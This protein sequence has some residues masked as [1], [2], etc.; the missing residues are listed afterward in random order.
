M[1]R[2]PTPRRLALFCLG[3]LLSTLPLSAATRTWTGTSSNLWSVAA[4]W[5]GTA[6]VA[7]D[8]LVFPAGAA[9]QSTMN[10]FAAGTS[11]NSI[12]ITG[13]SYT[14][15]GNAITLGAG[16]LSVSVPLQQISL[17]IT[18]GTSQMWQTT[19]I[20]ADFT[21]SGT[22]NLN[23]ATLTLAISSTFNPTILSGVISGAGAIVKTTGGELRVDGANTYTG[24]TTVNAGYFLAGNATAAGVADGTPA[25]G[26]I[27]NVNSSFSVTNGVTLGNEWISA[28]GFGQSGNGALQN[29]SC[30]NATY[31]GP[32]VLS[33]AVKISA[34]GPGGSIVFNGPISGSPTSIDIFGTSP[35]SFNNAANSFSGQL[36]IDTFGT[37][38]TV[39]VGATNAIPAAVTV[40]VGA[41]ETLALNNFNDTIA[42]LT[43]AGNVSL[44]SG[45]LTISGTSTGTFSGVISGTGSVTLGGAQSLTLSGPNTAM[46]TLTDNGSTLV[47]AGATAAWP[48]PVVLNNGS[49]A[50]LAS[51]A[52]IGPLTV[53]SGA[54]V[55][56]GGGGSATANTG[57]LTFAS[58]GVYHALITGTAAGAFSRLNVTGTVTLGGAT[59]S[60][61]PSGGPYAAGTQFTIIDNDGV[62][63]VTGTFA[64]LAQGATIS[65]G[66]QSYSIS[67]TAGTGNDVV[68]T[69]LAATTPTTTSLMSSTNPS[70]VGQPV[71]FTATVSPVNAPPPTGTVTFFDG[72]T[73]IGSSPVNVSGV[74]T[75][76]T[77]ALAAGPH[78]ITATYS[79]D[80]NYAGSTS[81]P[82]AQ[83]V[84]AA[85][86]PALDGR[87]L[88]ALLLALAVAGAV[89][90]KR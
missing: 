12:A 41:N 52:T 84:N 79:G 66:G 8:D 49:A 33:G 82:V 90:L 44:G 59:L 37:P 40:D 24:T 72:A 32:I 70:T 87:A 5:G 65:A 7:G 60:V 13:G 76:T 34:C 16:G 18:L 63:P 89:V 57:N 85:V 77:S 86:V 38:N 61:S 30:G 67:Y 53:N 62:D 55:T 69:V 78:S 20:T 14:L 35:I 73:N 39:N 22:I 15:A 17:P 3:I 26:T 2:S 9:N 29:A 54:Q 88:V 48:G 51:G 50:G 75:L 45:L 68:L 81:L 10:D 25:N 43:G 56:P 64:G 1:D 83:V 28:T 71:T 23:G 11:F 47:I 58:G 74:A 4:N 36:N 21:D 6:P 42:G 31:T 80:A 27:I 19:A 46:G